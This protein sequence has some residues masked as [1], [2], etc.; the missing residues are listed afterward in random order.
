MARKVIADRI[1]KLGGEGAFVVQKKVA[2]LRREGRN[3][4]ACHIGQPDFFTPKPIVDT[5]IDALNNGDHGYTP[6]GGKIE[7]REAAAEWLTKTRG[8][9]F[10]WDEMVIT[11][12][13]KPA[14]FLALLA[15]IEPGDEVIYPDP[16]YPTYGSVI[17]FLGAIPKPL[18]LV[19]ELGFRFQLDQLKSMI[20]PGKTRM[21]ILNSPENP[22]GGVLTEEDLKGIAELCH[23]YDM[24]C[25]SDEIYSQLV[26]GEK[27]HSI[28]QQPGMKERSIIMDG[29]SKTYAMTGWRL[30]FAGST[31]EVARA[32]E[33]LMTNSNSC[34]ASFTQT[35]GRHAL[36]M[37]QKPV[38]DMRAEFK[39]RRDMLVENSKKIPGVSCHM[40]EGAF[41]VFPN[42]KSFG[43]TSQEI[44]E[45][46]ITGAAKQ[47]IGKSIGVDGVSVL[48]GSAFG[49]YGEG[50]IRLS[51][52]NSYENLQLACEFMKEAFAKL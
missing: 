4:I 14:I 2:L 50:Y 43:K 26:Y 10:E 37:D 12:G 45:Y 15:T 24:L 44:E 52:A 31:K 7:M 13:A 47:G 22:T 33:L 41:Y 42:V 51:Y 9:K 21:I 36:L 48:A 11:P 23:K 30:G 25:F 3:I 5:A 35:A 27:H 39:R 20:T 6:S 8:V 19:E 18:P 38:D 40:P 34:A 1:S 28:V 29:H 46:L 17:P 16:G 49:K 32:M